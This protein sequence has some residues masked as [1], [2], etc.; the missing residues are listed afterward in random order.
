MRKIS[1]SLLNQN[2][3]LVKGKLFLEFHSYDTCESNK[4]TGQI[5]LATI[6]EH[7][8]HSGDKISPEKSFLLP[9]SLTQ[10]IPS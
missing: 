10:S 9:S 3:S 8:V 6:R 1:D 4:S 7:R 2:Q 5:I